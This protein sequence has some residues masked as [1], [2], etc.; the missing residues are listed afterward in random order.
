MYSISH[1]Q[2][3]PFGCVEG[4]FLSKVPS[5]D[6]FEETDTTRSHTKLYGLR[7]IY[8]A[9]PDKVPSHIVVALPSN[10]VPS[11]DTVEGKET[12]RSHPKLYGLR[13]IQQQLQIRCP[14]SCILSFVI[15]CNHWDCHCTCANSLSNLATASSWLLL[16][17]SSI[18]RA[19]S[20]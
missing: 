7:Q 2:H 12:T 13:Q 14:V 11:N 18:P 15:F 8:C 1:V 3:I 4:R 10:K 20:S 16:L 19:V 6:T 5:V 17:L 9:T